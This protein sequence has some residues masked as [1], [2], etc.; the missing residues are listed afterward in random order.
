MRWGNYTFVC[1]HPS[2]TV[3]TC[4]GEK[5]LSLNALTSM[6]VES[7]GGIDETSGARGQS[8]AP[9]ATR[10]VVEEI[11][12][13]SRDVRGQGS[14]PVATRPVVS[15]E[16]VGDVSPGRWI[17]PDPAPAS[18]EGANVGDAA[19]VVEGV[20]AERAAVEERSISSP[21]CPEAVAP[22]ASPSVP[23]IWLGIPAVT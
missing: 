12:G 11:D 5:D 6:D 13:K 10:P 23:M 16:G 8:S 1:E 14:A 15:E 20:V 17:A 18:P 3:T 21:C 4:D 7:C 2:L 9:V 22:P 19:E